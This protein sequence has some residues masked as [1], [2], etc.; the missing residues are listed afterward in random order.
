MPNLHL[1]G[2]HG[3]NPICLASS[4]SLFKTYLKYKLFEALSS[5][6]ITNEDPRLCA[7]NVNFFF[8]F[9]YFTYLTAP[10]TI[11]Q[12]SQREMCL[13]YFFFTSLKLVS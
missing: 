7:S 2:N 10:H 4:Y 6:P 3:L 12:V 11:L 8:A 1:V 13:F 5:L 9:S